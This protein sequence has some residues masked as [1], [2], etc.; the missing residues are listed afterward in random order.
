[1]P[2]DFSGSIACGIV[3]RNEDNQIGELGNDPS[4]GDTAIFPW[5][6]NSCRNID[7]CFSS[8]ENPLRETNVFLIYSN[9]KMIR[10]NQ[11][12]KRY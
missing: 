5:K 10:R 12:H 8:S 2:R 4:R 3:C 1:M 11:M 9:K 7:T 6:E